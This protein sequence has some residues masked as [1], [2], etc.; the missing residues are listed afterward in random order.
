METAG[1]LEIQRPEFSGRAQDSSAGFRFESHLA[2]FDFDLYFYHGFFNQPFFIWGINPDLSLYVSQ[3]YRK[4]TMWG[5][6]FERPI[7]SYVLRGEIGV[8]TD[9]MMV[10]L[11]EAALTADLLAGGQGVRDKTKIDFVLGL[12][13][14]NFIIKRLYMNMQYGASIL[15]N[16]E[17]ILIRDQTEH[18]F[19][20]KLEYTFAG[21]KVKLGAA[22]MLMPGR[23]FLFNPELI[24]HWDQSA[25]LKLGCYILSSEEDDYMFGNY[26][27]MDFIYA[28]FGVKF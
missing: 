3:E 10:S 4:I 9:G 5:F 24:W 1:T 16:H 15:A 13:T 21:D 22:S 27:A 20:L 23:G 7:A 14:L 19:T 8:F 6:D 26:G 18:V 12:D 2:G 28:R 25:E 17:D 11:N